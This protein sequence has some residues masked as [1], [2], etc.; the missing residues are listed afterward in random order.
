[1]ASMKSNR[2]SMNIMNVS[3]SIA[4]FF[5][6]VLIGSPAAV[7]ADAALAPPD[8]LPHSVA[9]RGRHD[10]AYAWLVAPTARYAH[11]VLGDDLEA[12]GLEVLLRDGR[13]LRHLLTTD[14]FEDLLPRV[15]DLD[16]DGRDEILLVRSNDQVGARLS[17][18]GVRDGRLQELAVGPAIGRGRRWLNPVGAADFDGDGRSE[19]AYVQTPHIG[20]VLRIVE[21]RHGEMPEEYRADGFS[22]HRIGETDLSSL[23]AIDDYDGDGIPDLK[24][25]SADYRRYRILRIQDNRL[26]ETG[27]H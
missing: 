4:V 6:L 1:M 12:A 10:I 7:T 13:R 18:W 19:I 14:V 25:M 21:Y 8:P 3:S 16:Q 2:F 20:G 9:G 5:T 17:V 26:I 15:Q 22:N 27:A 23:H 11:A 24:I